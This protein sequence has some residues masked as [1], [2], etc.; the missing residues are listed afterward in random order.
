M[1]VGPR[2]R[3]RG[4]ALFALAALSIAQQASADPCSNL[5]NPV[6]I[7]G[8]SAARPLIAAVG[9]ALYR[10]SPPITIV[11]L[12]GG[13][14]AGVAAVVSGTTISG[15]G[16]YWTDASSDGGTPTQAQCDLPAASAGQAVDIGASDVFPTSC[17]NVTSAAV[18]AASVT[19][20]W[21]PIQTM[22]FVAP[23]R[24]LGVTNISA[25]AA[26]VLLSRTDRVVAPWTGDSTTVVYRDQNSGTQTM[27]GK[28][29]HLNALNWTG[30]HSGGSSAGVMTEIRTANS[31]SPSPERYIG[32]LS[33]TEADS[34]RAAMKVLAFQATGKT[35][36][37]W[38]DSS[39]TTFD[40]R[41][42]RS[43]AYEIF[44][45]LHFLTKTNG[46]IPVNPNAAKIV[47]YF[48]GS[49]DPP[50]GP[51]RL[52]DIEIANH[53]VPRCAM[54]VER[55]SEMGALYAYS[56]SRPCGC[57]FEKMAGGATPAACKACAQTSDCASSGAN[58]ICSYGF[59]EVTR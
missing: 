9:A 25:E 20:F 34:E 6:Y 19:D 10:A 37:F 35:C 16:T 57:Y 53:T 44:G 32:V 48:D 51:T 4:S 52:M 26:Y 36:A 31:N 11:Y 18:T 30:G 40:K 39:L 41:N 59:C 8:S 47:S 54:K 46:Q 28:A 38:P 17:P 22:T 14:C 29:I 49:A 23:S 1:N 24:A 2:A 13:S 15:V 3:L 58:T 27:I 42:V 55:S 21:G 56:A 45:P 43:G 33:T 12:S 7:T 50:G 5:S